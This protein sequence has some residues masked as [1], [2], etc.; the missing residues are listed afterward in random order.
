MSRGSNRS[1]LHL[2]LLASL[3][4]AIVVVGACDEPSSSARPSASLIE[5]DYS[6][7]PTPGPGASGVASGEPT[8]LAIPVGWDN[9]FCGV[10]ADA[11]VAQ[12]LVIDIERALDEEAFRDARGLASD[13][14]DVTQDASGLLADLPPWDPASAATQRIAAQI[15]LASKAGEQYGTAFAE[16]S[17]TA[18]HR[19]R[20]LRRDIARETPATNEALAGLAQLGIG[21]EGPMQLETF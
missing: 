12:E 8:F 1:R 13:L 2:V 16:Q 6:P 18:L 3:A 7:P 11:V 15:D 21:C 10:M 5:I 19:A 14:R 20:S 17:S 4:L 9:A